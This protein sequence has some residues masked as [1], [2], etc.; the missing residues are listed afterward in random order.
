M[1]RAVALLRAAADDLDRVP[2]PFDAARLRRN[3][4][5]LLAA[6]GDREGA[7]RELRLAHDALTRLGAEREL[8]GAREQIRALGGRPPAR[9]PAAASG[10]GAG[11]A[12]GDG[13][14]TGR[15]LEIARLV[16]ARKSNREVGEA[17]GISARTVSTHLSNVFAKLGVRSRGEL[18]DWVRDQDDR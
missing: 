18:T 9:A 13:P 17:L 8:R 1:P 14:L 10:D 6:A 3:L 4:A 2:F 11:G 12:A 5:Q 16:A 7:I 15:E